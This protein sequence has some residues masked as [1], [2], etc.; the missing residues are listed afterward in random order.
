MAIFDNELIDNQ[1][2]TGEESFGPTP[3]LGSPD[4]KQVQPF[5]ASSDFGFQNPGNTGLTIDQLSSLASKPDKPGTWSSP[6]QMVSRTELMENSRY[7]V[8][9][10][11]V[12]LENIYGLQQ[13]WT[14]QLA[15]GVVKMGATAIGTFAQGLSNIPNAISSIKNGSFKDLSGNP[16]GYEGSID[17]W[18]KNIEDKF[19]NYYTRYEKEHPFLTMIPFT[20]GN[21]NFWGDKIIKNLGFTAGA[22]ASAAAQDIA[23]GMA[24]E[25]I[26]DIPLVA[27]QVGKASLWLNKLFTGANDVD[28]LLETARAAGAAEKAL[29]NIQKLGEMAAF[30]KVA[31]GFRYGA[32]IIGSAMTEAGVEARDGYSQ[33]KKELT[34]QYKDEYGVDPEGAAALEIEKYATDAMNVRFGTNMALLTVS[35]AIQFDNLFKS[36]GNA[37]KAVTGSLTRELEEAGKI[38]LKEGS[39]DLFEKKVAATVPGK[40]WDAV[41]PK[42]ANVLSE[43]VYEEGGQYAAE[44]GIYDYY[45]RKYKN[46]KDPEN[47]KNWNDLNE[48]MKSTTYGLG[49]QFGTEAGVE[50]MIIGALTAVITGGVQGTI[51]SYK[52]EGKDAR[53]QSSINILN[54]YG[55]TGILSDKYTNTLNSIG[56]AKEMDNAAKS[57]DV[58]SYKNLQHNLFYAFV[59]SRIPAGMHDVTIEQLNMLKDLQKEDFEKT[60]GMD[61]NTSNKETVSEYVDGLIKEANSIKTISDSI[62]NTF[63]NPFTKVANPSTDEQSKENDKYKVFEDWK[64]DLTYYASKVPHLNNRLN[65][66]Q[67]SVSKINPLVT[68]ELL[69]QLTDRESLQ[70]L[71]KSYEQ[72]AKDLEKS[73]TDATNVA[74]KKTIKD[75]IKALRTQSQRINLALNN[76]KFEVK[77]FS[78]ILNFELNNQDATKDEIV[79]LD[80]I[81]ELHNYGGDINKLNNLR[82][83]TADLFDKL[84]SEKGVETY[85]K[86]AEEMAA[87]DVPEETVEVPTE[88]ELP[89]FVN[90]NEQKEPINVG[91]EYQI[92]R[93]KLAKVDKLADDRWQVTAPNGDITFHK[94][95]EEANTAAEEA[96]GTAGSL[97]KVK[98]LAI[99]PDST[100]KVEDVNGDI[101]DIPADSLTGYEKIQTDQEKLQ[102]FS[103]EVEKEQD[104]IEKNSGE[105]AGVAEEDPKP[106]SEGKLKD[107]SIL[108]ISTT[109]E[110]EGDN[111]IAKPHQARAIEFLQNV[112]N[113]PDYPS[114]KAILVTL[115]QE[116]SLGLKGLAKQ[117]YDVSDEEAATPAFE[118]MATNL[119]DGLVAVV[120]VKQVG[121]D[122]YF[123]D[124]EGNNLSK[125]GEQVDMTKV[126]FNTMPTT[127]L[128]IGNRNRYRSEQEAQ[129]TAKAAAWKLE[130]EKIFKANGYKE[131]SF[132]VSRG[133]PKIT[134]EQNNVGDVLIPQNKVSSQEGLIQIS[135][136][137]TM[138]HQ[139][140]LVNVRVGAPMLQYGSVLQPLSGRRFSKKQAQGVFEVLKRISEDT[141]DQLAKG[142]PIKINRLYSTYLQNVLFWKSKA[143]ATGMNQIYIN[144]KTMDLM[145]SGVSFDLTDIANKEDEL[146]SFLQG[147]YQNIN[148]DT[149]NT[150]FSEPFFEPHIDPQGNFTVSEWTNYQTYLLGD[151][152]PD[153]T[154]RPVSDVPLYTK[155]AKP[156]PEVPY[157]FIQKYATLNELD[158]PV[159]VVEEKKEEK[160]ASPIVEKGGVVEG[161]LELTN[162]PV[163]YTASETG[164]G[165]YNITID[166]N[167][168][169]RTIAENKDVL[170][171]IINALKALEE[172]KFDATR[173]DIALVT[174]FLANRVSAELQAAKQEKVAETAP[175]V[176]NVEAK[177][178]VINIYWGSPESSTNTKILS[179]LAPRK[180]TYQGKDYGSVEHAYQ[181]LKS[182]SFD[183]VT[184]DK[185]VKAGGYGTKI[186][187]K[188]VTQGFDNLQ[189]MKDLVVES[190]KQNSNQAAL[191]LNYSDFTHTTNEVID[192]AFLEGIRIAQKN[193]ELAAL[194]GGKPAAEDKTAPTDFSQTGAPDASD[195][196]RS[197]GEAPRMTDAEI[198]LFKEWHAANTPNIPFEILDNIITTHDGQQAW[199]VFE[200][201]VAKF[202]RGGERGTEYHEVFH[203]IFNGFLSADD[204]R[205]ILDEFKSKIGKFKDRESGKMLYYDE[206]TDKQAEERIADDF[207]DFRLG[208]IPARSIGEK[209][210][211][212][213]RNILQFVKEFVKKPSRKEELFKAI[214]A[215]KFKEAEMNESAKNDLIQYRLIPGLTLEQTNDFVN[216]ITAQLFQNIF[217]TN[218]A[219]FN[220]EALTSAALFDKVKDAYSR[221]GK[222]ELLGENR[223][224]DLVIATKEFLRT[225]KIEFNEE[226][227][228]T[229]NDEN[230]TSRL[231]AAEPF[232]T[233]WKATSAYFVKV[234]IGTLTQTQPGSHKVNGVLK[235]PSPLLSKTINGLKL[236]NF[237][238]AFST[239]LDR[240]SNTTNV[241]SF[242]T[243]LSDLATD[244]ADYVRLFTRLKGTLEGGAT[245]DFTKFEPHDWRLFVNFYQTFSKQKPNAVIQYINGDEVYNA[246]ANQFTAIKQTQAGWI[247][248][249]KAISTT[250]DA[251]IKKV[252]N[253]YKVD[254]VSGVDIK[255]AENM[256][257]FLNKLGVNITMD[258]YVNI[259]AEQLNK[260]ADT[261]ADIKKYLVKNKSIYSV[262]GKTLG[263]NGPLTTLAEIIVKV[264]NPIQDNTFINI[265]GEKSQSYADNN[266]PS[267]FKNDFNSVATVD[268]LKEARPELKDVFTTNSVMLKK[269]GMFINADGKRIKSLS[270]EYING[271]KE[272]SAD[273]GTSTTGLTIG[274]RFT[275]EINQN[276]G[277]NYYVLIPADGSTE[278]MMNMGNHIKYAEVEGNIAWDKTY[279]IFQGYLR[280]EIA[281]AQSDRSYLAN[282]APRAKEL[283]FFKE[284]LSGAILNKVNKLI[285]E[286]ADNDTIDAFFADKDNVA[287]INSAVFNTINDMADRTIQTLKTNRKIVPNKNTNDFTY[288]DLNSAFASKT[289]EVNKKRLSDEQL[290]T[291]MTFARINYV[292]NNIEFHKVLFGDPYQFKIDKDNLLDE[293]KRIKSF[294]SPRRTTFDTPEFNTAHTQKFNK[295]GEIPLEGPSTNK[296]FG[297]PGYHTFKDYIDTVTLAD[298]I[299]KGLYGKNNEADAGSYIMDNTYREVKFKNGQ[300]TDEAETWHQWQ[301]AYTRNK[302]AAKG[303]Y[304]YT[305]EKLKAQDAETIKTPAT[306]F[307]T[308][309]LKPIVSG[310]KYGRNQFDM[311]LDKFSQMPLYYSQIEGTNL[312][313]LYT[314]LWKEGIGY[315]VFES[316]RKVGAEKI[317]DLYKDG[318][319]NNEPYTNK[320]PV[321]WKTYG[322]QVENAYSGDKSQTRGSQLTKLASLDIF[323]NSQP[324]SEDAKNEYL[325]NKKILK[326]LH[327]EGYNQLLKRLGIEDLGVGNGFKIIDYVSVSRA[328]EYEMLR[329]EL[330]Q[331]AKD[332]VQL[333]DEKQ[334]RILFEASPAYLQIRN[335]LYSMV[336]K[337][338]VSP[339][340]NGGPKVQVPV[341]LWEDYNKKRDGGPS[342]KLKFYEDKDGARYC[343]VL[344][345]HWFKDQFAKAGFKSDEELLTY[346]NKKENESILKGIGFRIPT[347]ALSSVEVFKVKGFLPQSMGD[348]VVVPSEI[349]TKSGSDFDI[350]KLNMYLKNTYVT[351]GGKLKQV[352]FFGYGQE[353]K[354]K[355]KKFILEEDLANVLDLNSRTVIT[356]EDDYTTL[357]DRLYKQSLENE[358][359]DSL[360]KMI[361]LPQNY[362]RLISPVTDGGLKKLAS[363]INDL[364]GTKDSEVKNRMIDP[365]YLTALRN[366]FVMAK[367]WVGIGAVNITNHSLAQKSV[368]YIDPAKIAALD[369]YQ[370][371]L[372]GNGTIMLPHN[373][374]EVNGRKVITISGTKDANDRNY[375]S[376][377][378]SGYITSFV[379]VAKDPYIT[380]IIPS[381][382]V[383]GTFMFLQRIGVPTETVG[384]F[385][386][387]PIIKEYLTYLDSIS[388]KNV[389]KKANLKVIRDMF[390]TKGAG[391]VSKIID[392]KNLDRN[393]ENYYKNNNKL[394]AAKNVEQQL[395]LNEFLKYHAMSQQMFKLTQATN[396][397]TTKFKNGEAL[398][399]KQARTESAK[400]TNIFSSVEDILNNS[401]IGDQAELLDRVMDGMGEI[402]KL[403]QPQFVTITKRVLNTFLNNEYLSAD[404]FDR[405]S[406]KIK[407]SLLD[408]IIQTKGK[409]NEDLTKLLINPVTSVADRLAQAKVLYPEVKILSYLD[410]ATS[411]RD[412]GA[413]SI[414]LIAKADLAYD[415]DLYTNMMREM[416]DTPGTAELYN[417]V[418]KLAMLQGTYQ[419]AISIQSII[420]IEDYSK[421]LND[422]MATLVANQDLDAFTDGSFQKNNWDDEDIVPTVDIKPKI[423][424]NNDLYV[425]EFSTLGG[426]TDEGAKQLLILNQFDHYQVVNSDY[427]KVKRFVKYNNEWYDVVKE[428]TITNTDYN[429]RKTDGDTTLSQVIGYKKVM[430][431]VGDRDTLMHVFKLTN[432]LGDGQFAKEHY[433]DD[434]KSVF[435]NGT[436][437]VDNEIPDGKII[438]IYGGYNEEESLTS[439]EGNKEIAPEDLPAIKD[440]NQNNCG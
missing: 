251:L 21:A 169:V 93:N 35:N 413:K 232:S 156:T 428:K 432:L 308:D 363:R 172:D 99:N 289:A 182:G 24:T 381:N 394:S 105:I 195:Y 276:L 238:K 76:K 417:D 100:I 88:T 369:S 91:R 287:A 395:I 256:L 175:V 12:D 183:Q 201:G 218:M 196:R 359:Y 269:G 296:P 157:N 220:P 14:S 318:E 272:E 39:L 74:D 299:T 231:Y 334:F 362:E 40:L 180:F 178:P 365:N 95:E 153:G 204:R 302:L 1:S 312:E 124:K 286:N 223:W 258:Q 81:A 44:K 49:Q 103:N 429:S 407:A 346:L 408:Y 120:Y 434:R 373:T 160:V 315:A 107:E 379:D 85:F 94:T 215:G 211:R 54:Q 114:M 30:T 154:A 303:T 198:Q 235:N 353:A 146:V 174:T 431:Y 234:L 246:P 179:N 165:K 16:D 42:L 70:D 245:I 159:Q 173:S 106:L 349:T 230:V 282:T 293:T 250:P 130:R 163:S 279:K 278:W 110:E 277:G 265:D 229:I 424:D 284:I 79:A 227:A 259:K 435:N 239:L 90:K 297:D 64:T 400:Q 331:N 422:I 440:N 192:K 213:F 319:F 138:S 15:N 243:K 419:S 410:L 158:L 101:I 137:G 104:D 166:V 392:V 411:D 355:I 52:G 145:L 46:L 56:I 257:K 325:R 311:V 316:G 197:T 260:F 294:L 111:F 372:F 89:T 386:N 102:K 127:S 29:L 323:S 216:D 224:N 274:D 142:K 342:D 136:T 32:G 385:M 388:S 389:N 264:N 337:A 285:L 358:Y 140:N 61:F 367:K 84:S 263:I 51:D 327:T 397:D 151:T 187:G 161:T 336:D 270:V 7:P 48:I 126:V 380:S 98:V 82:R 57:G 267:I 128:K 55:L 268:Q 150:K 43:G 236:L 436:L 396:Y 193:A 75:Q 123:V 361:S 22:I 360:E 347:Q 348:T 356:G 253:T 210:L 291:I 131:Y 376:D 304:T 357:A 314:K 219:L 295:A 60:F 273:S 86:Q 143:N 59:Q 335:I 338:L 144:P 41:K 68:N 301:M 186:R 351:A 62:A 185:Y 423:E 310:N 406:N 194:E 340:M 244:D 205:A 53:L 377:S 71:S 421:K 420:P 275:Q 6:T 149:L 9:E 387:Q 255:G 37:S 65:S 266:A 83:K 170:S 3:Y 430:T 262:T 427:V 345:P 341:T 87:Q 67:E 119:D 425:T 125:V 206:A 108:F 330:S 207:A 8:Y 26:A 292:I 247:E 290:K 371:N 305:N 17:N 391:I 164:D 326:E 332:T 116:E 23:L 226:D 58:Y 80:K 288:A 152:Y 306:E 28:K 36:F 261:V 5:V 339:K 33:V 254:N 237:S 309:E 135:T 27:N 18:L 209:I 399:K 19:P 188:A 47:A 405:I 418:V 374:V 307:V 241:P 4:T 221:S 222:L 212:F 176:S 409:L 283:R 109:S 50:N 416:R 375:I 181:T 133:I 384:L 313:K 162:G 281:L 354:D 25:G 168:T 31:S 11:G 390:P 249:I 78:Q 97:A 129:A 352:P 20:R 402:L 184:Y 139:G 403:E 433:V 199:G 329:R 225:F 66:I 378:L 398:L 171:N 200:Q 34:Q 208:K 412:G 45:T 117:S 228:L 350:D 2:G 217:G 368:I 96:N 147:M 72:K 115:N 333:N 13:G 324:I 122:L 203:G 202:Y 344:V 426:V 300:W 366:A 38:G 404:K 280:D 393:I 382:L 189:L 322:I 317:Y 343:E 438:S 132:S 77:D 439:Q 370:R 321:A 118:A 69:A 298:I 148:R 113:F 121:P 177:K 233:D 415:K 92:D 414:K 134:G 240:L 191:L 248:N 383:V 214:E 63:K 364:R 167:D 252:G 242:I 112:E 401:F 10:R 437:Q 73:I 271:T 155:V 328:L 141:K 320:I 190:F